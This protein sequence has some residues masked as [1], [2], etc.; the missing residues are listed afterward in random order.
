MYAPASASAGRDG[1]NVCAGSQRPWRVSANCGA[2]HAQ[3]GVQQSE[4]CQR[5]ARHA[6][7][8]AARHA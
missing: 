1:S 6:C 3:H 7:Q 2:S 8:R 4:A 5:A